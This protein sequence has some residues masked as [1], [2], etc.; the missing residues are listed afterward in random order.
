MTA[1]DSG[2]LT[3]TVTRRLDPRMVT[4]TFQTVPGG[5]S[6]IVGGTS[7]KSS[8][9]RTV[10][11]GSTNTVSA[12]SPQAKGNKQYNFF[13]WSD[14]GAQSHTIVAPAGPTTYTARYK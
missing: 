11:V 9:T 13:S 5:L 12:V 2:G 8:F 1:T 14:G 6:L 3:S 10:I 7:V 4:L